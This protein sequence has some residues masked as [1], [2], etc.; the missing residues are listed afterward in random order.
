MSLESV[1]WLV[2]ATPHQIKS[3]SPWCTKFHF[4]I[5]SKCHCIVAVIC[6]TIGK[7]LNGTYKDAISRNGFILSAIEVKV[8]RHYCF[9]I[10]YYFI[11][12]ILRRLNRLRFQLYSLFLNA[13]LSNWPFRIDLWTSQ[14]PLSSDKVTY[15]NTQ[16]AGWK[17]YC[18]AN[19]P[20]TEFVCKRQWLSYTFQKNLSVFFIFSLPLL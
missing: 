1:S 8:S 15:M 5:S 7:Y 2:T 12:Y 9:V 19:K 18:G 6:S 17:I 4:S 20:D 16:R 11:Q 10:L 13:S 3:L 14:L